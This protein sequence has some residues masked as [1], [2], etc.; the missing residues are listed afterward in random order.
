M[1][2][3]AATWRNA[4][5]RKQWR[6]TLEIQ[7]ASIWSLPVDAVDTTVI[8][9]VL[10]P[11]WHRKAETARRLRGRIERILDAGRA[12]GHRGGDNPAR[13]RGHLDAILPRTAKLDGSKYPLSKMA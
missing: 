4:T 6:Q 1:A 7:A 9:D 10:R 5:H 11:I 3:R 2:D 13:W 8:I 12:A